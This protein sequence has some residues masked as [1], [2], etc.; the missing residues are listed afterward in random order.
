MSQ[1]FNGRSARQQR[2]VAKHLKKVDANHFFNLLTSPRLLEQ[3]EVHRERKFPPTVAL[4]MFLGQV[5]SADGSCQKAVDEALVTRVL[6]GMDP[7]SANTSAYCQARARLPEGMIS[8]LA[9]QT[10]TLL[11]ENTPQGWLW[12]GRPVKL[13]DGT[14]AWMPDTPQNQECFPQSEQQQ[15]GAGFPL[16]RLVGV[17]SLTHG[18]VLDAAMGA[19]QG[20]GTGA[21]QFADNSSDTSATS[22]DKYVFP[23]YDSAPH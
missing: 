5:M 20:K 3:V 10:A 11:S 7:G 15:A 6:S 9:R 4:T 17:I 18:A 12:R 22:D 8:A 14:T 16:A 23:L 2:Q 13:V 19:Y 1:H 21:G